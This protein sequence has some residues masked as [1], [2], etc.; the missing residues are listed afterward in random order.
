LRQ[1]LQRRSNDILAN[2]TNSRGDFVMRT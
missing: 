2:G 1:V